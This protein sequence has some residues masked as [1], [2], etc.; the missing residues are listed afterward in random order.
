MKSNFKYI[1]ISITGSLLIVFL[2]QLFWLKGLYNTIEA[3]TEK[4]IF[5]CLNIANSH[6]LEFRMD[7]LENS[8]DK[9][10]IKGSISI[11][12]SIENDYN[13]EEDSSESGKIIKSKRIIQGGDTIQ[14]KKEIGDEEFS[15]AQFER[16][17]IMIRETMHQ[18]IDSIAP[19]RLDT[20]HAALL[21]ALK[22]RGIK[23]YIYKIEVVDFTKDSV[24]QSFDVA[25]MDKSPFVFNY[26]YDYANQLGYRVYFESLTKTILL[27]MLGI[28]VTT[29]LIILILVLAFWY[30]I[31]TIFQ[32]KTLNEM[33][34]DFTNNMTHELKTPIAVAYSA[35]DAM[36][37]FRQGENKER[38]ERYLSITKGQLENLSSLVEQILSMSTE[39]RLKLILK[40]EDISIKSMLE[41]LIEQHRMKTEREV[42]FNLDVQPGDLTIYADRTHLNNVISNLI[43]NAIKYSKG[44][45]IINIAAYRDNKYTIIIIE[46]N[47]IGI[48]QDK[49]KFLFEKFYRVPQGNKHDAKGYGI[50]LFYVKTIVGKHG[51]TIDVESILGNGSE[52][53]IKIPNE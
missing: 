34:D 40:K 33:K 46:D 12:Q 48:A 28:L 23:S 42:V 44:K 8:S 20:L 21:P 45:A 27:Q 2:I 3:E 9:D 36:L 6:E 18:T 30:L 39:R 29:A 19:I 50:G 43:D 13:E 41:V 38:R 31:R 16:L 47:G 4:N 25:E 5:E 53:T 14:D 32:Q 22:M 52:F 51:G 17:G 10:R 11:T 26:T 49:Q 35:T 37:N 7:S 1:V 24:M 15:L